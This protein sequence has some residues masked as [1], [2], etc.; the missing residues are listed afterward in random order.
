MVHLISYGRFKFKLCSQVSSSILNISW[1][2]EEWVR[3][4]RWSLIVMSDRCCHWCHN[5]DQYFIPPMP[6]KTTRTRRRRTRSFRTKS[7][8]S[9]LKF[10]RH[11]KFKTKMK[12]LICVSSGKVVSWNLP[13]KYAR[14]LCLPLSCTSVFSRIVYATLWS[15]V[16]S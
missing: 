15:S 9:S 16:D 10:A 1:K 13:G 5:I 3:L 11:G 12:Q 7:S 2:Y 4:R 8:T 14:E 6:P